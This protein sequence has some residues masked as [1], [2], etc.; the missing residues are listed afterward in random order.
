M[1]GGSAEGES[2]G[3]SAED[4]TGAVAPLKTVTREALLVVVTATDLPAAVTAMDRPAA[5]TWVH[6]Q[7]AAIQ[8]TP[9]PK[10]NCAT[11]SGTESAGGPRPRT[12]RRRCGSVR[13]AL[14]YHAHST[15]PNQ[16]TDRQ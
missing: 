11:T 12:A 16:V 14:K 4:G 13:L 6:R 10:A 3:G 5:V 7:A 8:E 2:G 9:A 1:N 15:P